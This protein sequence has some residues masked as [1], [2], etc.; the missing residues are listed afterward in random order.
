MYM[1]PWS[2]PAKNNYNNGST[3][4]APEVMVIITRTRN[5]NLS[6]TSLH[7]HYSNGESIYS[8]YM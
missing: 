4:D 7:I 6:E 5:I 1:Y 3:L 8:V 2:H